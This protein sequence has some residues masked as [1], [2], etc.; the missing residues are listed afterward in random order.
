MVKAVA[1]GR[2]LGS[3]ISLTLK[4]PAAATVANARKPTSA[5]SK[6]AAVL[7]LPMRRVL[8]RTIRRVRL[9]LVLSSIP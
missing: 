6:K 8:Q 4:G 3:G 2:G 1:V 5:E 7:L 9:A